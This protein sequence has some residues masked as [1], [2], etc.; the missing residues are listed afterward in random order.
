MA[1]FPTTSTFKFQPFYVPETCTYLF[2]QVWEFMV[3]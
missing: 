2:S 1:D 3:H